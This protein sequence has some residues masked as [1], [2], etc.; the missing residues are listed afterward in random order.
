MQRFELKFVIQPKD[1]LF[2]L[3]QLR[4]QGRTGKSYDVSSIYFDDRNL[5][6]YHAKLDGLYERHKIRIRSYSKDFK[7]T[8]LFLER[9][10]RSGTFISK[11]RH[12]ISEKTL[13]HALT[14]KTTEPWLT[15]L[16]PTLTV[17]YH[18][19]E[20]FFPWGRVTLDTDIT[21]KCDRFEW[22]HK[23][24]ILEVKTEAIFEA[25]WLKWLNKISHVQSFSKYATGM[26]IKRGE[27][28]D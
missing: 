9:K 14:G 18:R 10:K 28:N 20:F 7:E 8:P 13:A 19:Q 23:D 5:S 6:S 1:I 15:G 27:M 22:K 25:D 21:F 12:E 4:T 2:A 17:Y 24:A 16:Y 26:K 3:S 11:K